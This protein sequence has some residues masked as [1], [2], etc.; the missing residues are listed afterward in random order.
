MQGSAA[1][2]FQRSE[3]AEKD[4]GKKSTAVASDN[5]LAQIKQGGLSCITWKVL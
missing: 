1:G 2:T 3:A 5:R 4:Q